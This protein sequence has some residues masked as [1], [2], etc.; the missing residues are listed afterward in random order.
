LSSF[1]ADP[2]TGKQFTATPA[3]YF[4]PAGK[5]T[6]ANIRSDEV[7]GIAGMHP[8]PPTAI[9]ALLPGPVNAGPLRIRTLQTGG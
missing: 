1:H 7:K 3:W 5:S 8:L 6:I 9:E 2:F 4:S